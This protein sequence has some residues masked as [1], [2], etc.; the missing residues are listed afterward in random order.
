MTEPPELQD[1]DL[2]HAGSVV[3][4]AIEYM[5]GQKITSMAIASALLGGAMGVL[6]RTLPEG[7]IV[8]ILQNAIDSVESG[9]MRGMA[10]K[11]HAGEA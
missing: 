4:K 5:M 9:E 7:V 1:K 8:Q 11:D 3:D 10:G 6:S 2:S